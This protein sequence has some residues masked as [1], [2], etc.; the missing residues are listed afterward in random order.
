MRRRRSVHRLVRV[1]ALAVGLVV[2]TPSGMAVAA[3]PR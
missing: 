2:L 3:Q 1:V